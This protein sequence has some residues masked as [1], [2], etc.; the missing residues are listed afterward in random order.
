MADL[1]EGV[2]TCH[3]RRLGCDGADI[4]RIAEVGHVAGYRA[5][6][7]GGG[8]ETTAAEALPKTF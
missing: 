3:V 8:E 4:A 1:V 2:G 6:A 5:S 7:G